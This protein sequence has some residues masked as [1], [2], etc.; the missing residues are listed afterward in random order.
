MS[1]QGWYRIGTFLFFLSC[2]AL[3]QADCAEPKAEPDPA[4]T[5]RIDDLIARLGHKQFAE[6]ERAQKELSEMGDPA[7]EPL[8]KAAASTD[9]EIASRAKECLPVLELN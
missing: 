9:A 6:R 5:K 3:D 4:L 8:R 7:L 2:C 1:H